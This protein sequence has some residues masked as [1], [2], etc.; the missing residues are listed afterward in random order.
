VFTSALQEATDI[1]AAPLDKAAFAL[2]Q[3]IEGDILGAADTADTAFGSETLLISRYQT[4]RK[5]VRQAL[6]ILE[7][8]PLAAS[9]AALAE[10]CICKPRS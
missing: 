9:G 5:I 7:S 2:T 4:S 6:R 8:V 10:D 3:R 1:H